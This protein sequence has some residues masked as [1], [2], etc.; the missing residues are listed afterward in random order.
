MGS[1]ILFGA[2]GRQ[3]PLV[4]RAQ[5]IVDRREFTGN[6]E[7]MSTYIVL[8]WFLRHT[9]GLSLQATVKQ[10]LA[11]AATNSLALVSIAGELPEPE[12]ELPDTTFPSN[13]Y[14]L[15]RLKQ[16]EPG[17]CVWRLTHDG[18]LHAFVRAEHGWQHYQ[19]LVVL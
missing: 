4:V 8:N 11:P 19:Q 12:Q 2:K 7:P 9:K 6:P 13:S 10:G 5:Q 17:Q 3:S 14:H 15:Y 1:V 18:R 16:V